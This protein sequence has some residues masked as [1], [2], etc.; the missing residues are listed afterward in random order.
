ME[1]TL[2]NIESQLKNLIEEAPFPIGVYSGKELKIV[3]A[4]KA[5]I[6]TYGKGN[7][8]VG[9]SY[10][11]VLPE[12]QGTGIFE[13]F[14]EVLETGIPYH[15]KNSRVDLVIEGVPTLH[16]F[17]YA[18]TPMS[19]EKGKVYA[20]MN[21]GAD[22][23]DLN[24]ARQQTLE[25]E[26]KL[27]LA[28]NSAEL[29]TY[30]IHLKSEEVSISGNFR[31]LWDIDD[32]IIT[33]ELIISRMHPDDLHIRDTA[34]REIGPEGMVSYETR[35]IH[36]DMSMHWLRINGT[37]IKDELGKPVSLVGIAQDITAQKTAQE[38][39]AA[40]VEQRTI[41]LKRSNDD[42][43]QFSHIVSHDLKEPLR[44]IQVYNNLL[45]NASD[46]SKHD[47]YS[48]KINDAAERMNA[49]IEGILAYSATNTVGFPVE[50]TDLNGIVKSI[51]R[52]LELVIDEKKAILIDEALPTL[53]GSPILLQRLFY[54]LV[55]NALKFSRPDMPPRVTISSLVI[56]DKKHK[57]V[58]ITIDDNGIGI[59]PK[60]VEKIFNAFERLHSKDRFEGTGLGL[61]LCKKIVERH[62]GVIYAK[63]RED[64][65]E[66]IVE[67]PVQQEKEFV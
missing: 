3:L 41:Q 44:K 17:N 39:L 26:E 9:K 56:D 30:E 57:I 8:V 36:R 67:L 34:W 65:S 43:V 19:D 10:F 33:K 23:T 53:E 11:E 42:L 66:F 16:Y 51:K 1:I 22:V 63:G 28:I 58:R 13:K 7:D 20:V 61:A 31:K 55:S 59:E 15:V 14:L 25:A 48:G 54:N 27:R 18:I 35:I 49:L 4:N 62:G 64:G 40:I 12:L 29:G 2:Q 52:D 37:I 38:Q 45:A 5:M 6:T 32:E 50:P 46:K 60:F 21:T 24:I 47:E